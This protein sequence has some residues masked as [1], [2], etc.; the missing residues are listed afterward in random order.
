MPGKASQRDR[1]QDYRGF[2]VECREGTGQSSRRKAA[3]PTDETARFLLCTRSTSTE[4]CPSQASWA[5]PFSSICPPGPAGLG[6]LLSRQER[7]RL[8]WKRSGLFQPK[9]IRR[10]KWGYFSHARGGRPFRAIFSP[11]FSHWQSQASFWHGKEENRKEWPLKGAT[12][13]MDGV[14]VITIPRSERDYAGQERVVSYPAFLPPS[15]AASSSSSL[16]NDP[17]WPCRSSPG[18]TC[19]FPSDPPRS[20]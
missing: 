10:P 15:S 9:S 11:T 20:A 13:I 14:E 16:L 7:R 19:R 4:R 18:T 8:P 12:L 6:L 1:C 5:P 2:A 17:S 3:R